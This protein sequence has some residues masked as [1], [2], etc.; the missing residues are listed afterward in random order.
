MSN[1]VH[2]LV[3][4]NPSEAKRIYDKLKEHYPIVLTRDFAKAKSWIRNQARGTERT[5]LLAHSNGMRLKPEGIYVKSE[6][7]CANWFLNDKYDVRSSC[8]LEDCATEFDVQ[9]LELDWAILAWDANL[10]RNNGVWDYL[11]FEGNKWKN[12]KKADDKKYLLNAYRVLLTRARQGMVIFLPSGDDTDKSRK[13]EFYNGIY[14]YLTNCGI[15]I[16]D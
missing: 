15:E 16:L 9:G 5:G 13:T 2:A 4:N 3:N 8:A 14:D 10:R 7:D 6:I 12:I 11:K 1:F